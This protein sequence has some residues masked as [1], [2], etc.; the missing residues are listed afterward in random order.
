MDAFFLGFPVSYPRLIFGTATLWG[1]YTKTETSEKNKGTITHDSQELEFWFEKTNIFR[2]SRNVSDITEIS[3]KTH[4]AS[5]KFT[6]RRSHIVY[7][8]SYKT[9]SV[10]L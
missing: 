7:I 4:V 2:L 10:F 9:K 8:T 1:Y 3:K 6:N 5:I